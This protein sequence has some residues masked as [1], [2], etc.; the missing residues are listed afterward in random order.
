MISEKIA[1]DLG[2][3]SWIR[4]MFEEGERLSAIYGRE[5]VFD[6]SLGNPVD[7]PPLSV[8]NAI[9]EDAQSVAG[10][11]HGYMNNAGYADSRKKIASYINSTKGSSLTEKHI[12]MTCGAA[13]GLNV[14][15][16]TLL[17]PGDEVIVFSP[18]FVE[19]MF[20][21]GNH[22]GIPVIVPS[23]REDFQPDV[24]LFESS[25][26]SKTR[27]VL[28]NSPNNPTGVVYSIE[29]LK[30]MALVI[31]EKSK[32]FNRNIFVISDEPYERIVYDGVSVPSVFEVFKNSLL[33]NSFSKSHSLP[34]ERIG[35]VALN[36]KIEGAEQIISGL[37][38]CNRILGYVNAPATMQRIAAQTIGDNIDVGLYRQKRD[39]LYNMLTRL[40]FEC[41]KPQGAFYIFPKTPIDD[42]IEFAKRAQKYNILIVP[43]SGF[44]CPGYFRIAY[45][46]SI[47]T[48]ERSIPSFEKL[49][50]EF[51]M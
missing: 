1:Q 32:L 39:L 23:R 14:A 7:E 4:K 38:F 46:C 13:G 2:K 19:Y 6:F 11:K 43:G 12:I 21:I 22:G 33:V 20:Y 24:A 17:D 34:G 49:A 8:K 30:Q 5:N 45:C 44:G 48:I 18:Y 15:L 50:L 10:G 31:D 9:L 26:S 29:V 51:N 3:S 28:I 37:T 16:K 27:A 41:R 42:D 47:E 40:G 35:Y 25:F 36:S